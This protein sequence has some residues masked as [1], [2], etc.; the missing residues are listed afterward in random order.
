MGLLANGSSACWDIAVD[1]RLDR[2]EWFLEID[3]PR[4]YLVFQLE[5][6]EVIPRALE[7]LNRAREEDGT[8]TL[9][10][11]GSDRV[12]LVWDN[13]GFQRC[14][15][16]I[17]QAGSALRL[18]FEAED[19]KMLSEALSQVAADLPQGLTPRCAN[20]RGGEPVATGVP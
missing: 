11:F 6:L 20:V 4:T 8:L 13:E 9:G 5:G 18:G 1:A 16:V 14:F 19:I 17:G 2:E 3:G 7:L 12:S 10:R 15:V